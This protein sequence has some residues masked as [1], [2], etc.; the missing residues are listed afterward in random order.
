MAIFYFHFSA[1]PFAVTKK[2]VKSIAALP[3]MNFTIVHMR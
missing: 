2:M 3:A 1:R